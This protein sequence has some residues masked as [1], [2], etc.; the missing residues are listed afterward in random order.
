MSNQTNQP[1]T[2]REPFPPLPNSYYKNDEIDLKELFLAL[3]QGKW[4]VIALTAICAILA[5]VYAVKLPNVYQSNATLRIDAD[6]Y[7]FVE[8]RGFNA[9]GQIVQEASASLPY[10]N[11]GDV[12]QQIIE[13]SN[14]SSEALNWLAIGKDREGNITL[15]KQANSPELAYSAVELYAENINTAFKQNELRK[16]T[17]SIRATEDLVQSQT[18]KVQDVLAE[19]YAQLLYKKA[20]LE[21]A[22]TELIKVIQQPVKP[23]SHIK[24]KRA[25]IVVLGTMLGGMLGVAIVLIR[26]AFRREEP[27]AE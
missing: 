1:L 22:D 4:I 26:F 18:G 9:G 3:W 20:I 7:S 16:V 15:S 21:S 25:L 17:S 12:K 8:T 14:S 11:S 23:T 6:P 13:T 24:P 2:A 27:V 5:T 10:L 19:K